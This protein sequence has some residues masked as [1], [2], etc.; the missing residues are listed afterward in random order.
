MV[1]LDTI[2]GNPDANL[3][4]AKLLAKGLQGVDVA[5]FPEMWTLGYFPDL[6][7]FTGRDLMERTL[8]SIS[9]LAREMRTYVVAGSIPESE[10]TS[11]FNTCFV[12]GRDGKPAGQYRKIHLF[13][14]LAEDAVFRRGM[15]PGFTRIDGVQAGLMIC[16]DLRFPELARSLALA[17]ARV[18]FT[19]AQWPVQR[20]GHWRALLIA[21][22][23][24]NQVFM[25]GVNATGIRNGV[26]FGGCSMIVDPW[27]KVIVEAGEGEGVSVGELALEEVD[28]VRSVIPVWEDRMP[29]SYAI[30]I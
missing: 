3:G 29:D 14:P 20:L 23:I 8:V 17:G 28:R 30:D 24:E 9:E 10:G 27:G 4:K 15:A 7:G 25:V 26:R 21:R 6:G 16:Y 19:V 22:A 2:E 1:Q 12:F 5:V 18:I 13:R 11:V